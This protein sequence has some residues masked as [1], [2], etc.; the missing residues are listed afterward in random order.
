MAAPTRVYSEAERNWVDLTARHGLGW[1]VARDSERLVGFVNVIWE[2]WRMRG[3][4]HD[5]R[6]S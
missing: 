2:G 1:V 6:P 5:G 3:P 4:G